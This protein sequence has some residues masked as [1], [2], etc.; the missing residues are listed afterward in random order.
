M[1][2]VAHKIIAKWRKK[3][4]LPKDHTKNEEIS[5]CLSNEYKVNFFPILLVALR[6]LYAINV[7][8]FRKRPCYS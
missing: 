2:V 6:P 7:N 5:W 1:T 3:L 4:W 8:D